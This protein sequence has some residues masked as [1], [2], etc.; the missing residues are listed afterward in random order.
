M[1]GFTPGMSV[2]VTSASLDL[3]HET[4]QSTCPPGSHSLILWGRRKKDGPERSRKHVLKRSGHTLSGFLGD[5]TE[6]V[7]EPEINICCA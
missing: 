6:E 1:T 2:D 7:G 4:E 5:H 3:A